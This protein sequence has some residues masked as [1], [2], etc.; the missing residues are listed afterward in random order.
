M[1]KRGW[2]IPARTTA[3]RRS[4]A[5]YPFFPPLSSSRFPDRIR[6][7]GLSCS[8]CSEARALRSKVAYTV[9][10]LYMALGGRAACVACKFDLVQVLSFFL[11]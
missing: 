11:T 10:L 1:P 9:F 7:L 6:T 5:L 4:V 3:N 8:R 2:N